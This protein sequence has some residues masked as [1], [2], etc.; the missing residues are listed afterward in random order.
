M[1]VISFS[2]R[3][4]F[5]SWWTGTHGDESLAD[6]IASETML[7]LASQVAN[8]DL[9]NSSLAKWIIGVAR[10][11]I[12]D[13]YRRANRGLRASQVVADRISNHHATVDAST[14]LEAGET[15]THVLDTLETI[16]LDER[17]ALEWKYVEELSVA[18]IALRMGRS[19]KG[20]ESLLYRA[21]QSFRSAFKSRTPDLIP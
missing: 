4:D 11:K 18:E 3:E 17:L 9:E 6:D 1:V 16:S 10:H 8:V 13:V 15:R 2:S 7:T 12:N 20:I 21:R 14:P 19:E 5:R